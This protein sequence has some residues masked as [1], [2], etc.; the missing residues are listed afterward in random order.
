MTDSH[1]PVTDSSG[2]ALVRTARRWALGVLVV[3]TVVLAGYL[4]LVLVGVWL[5][6]VTVE[7]VTARD[8]GSLD[9]AGLLLAALP[10]LVLGWGVG[11]GATAVLARSEVL[12]ARLSG[13]AAGAVGVLTGAAVLAV[14]GVL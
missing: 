8:V 14:T 7:A 9:V 1:L 10:G 13:L 6:G 2:S 4:V 5:V 3:G 11:L 12:G